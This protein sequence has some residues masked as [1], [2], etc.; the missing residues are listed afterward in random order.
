MH[1][2]FVILHYITIEDTVE[3]VESIRTNMEYENYSIIIV[4][5]GSPNHSGDILLNKYKD[6]NNIEVIISEENLGFAKG[7][8]I[9][10][11]HAKYNQGADFIVLINNDT[12]IEQKEF[13]DKIITTYNKEKFHVLGP[14]IL[15]LYDKK[16]Q[17]PVPRII[18]NIRDVE[19]RISKLSI[20]KVLNYFRIDQIVQNIKEKIEKKNNVEVEDIQLHGSCLIFSR[21]YIE[22]YDGLYSKTFMYAEECIL[23]YICC[24]DNLNMI[25][26]PEL[27]IK[28]KEDSSTNAYLRKDYLK[29]RFYYN[30]TIKSYKLLR[31]LFLSID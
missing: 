18:K 3:C 24:R 19:K 8:N 23:K 20:L 26:V 11:I 31:E 7:N 27:Q 6:F 2:A 16:H 1:I 5:N 14:D 22:R 30:N 21:K 15:S 4:D 9:G 29:R 25:Y 10:F 13:C 12:I 17:N 28:H